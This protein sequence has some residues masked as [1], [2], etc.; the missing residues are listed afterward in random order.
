M[1]NRKRKNK[2]V[3]EMMKE[4][5][6]NNKKCNPDCL[7]HKL[8]TQDGCYGCSMVT[9]TPHFFKFYKRKSQIKIMLRFFNS[10]EML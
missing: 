10:L 3:R 9:S 4:I 7:L 5:R 2:L 6:S 8:D 1:K